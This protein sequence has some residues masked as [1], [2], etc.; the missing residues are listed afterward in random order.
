LA[1]ACQRIAASK[2]GSYNGNGRWD[3]CSRVA[4]LQH[5]CASSGIPGHPAKPCVPDSDSNI[6]ESQNPHRPK[7]FGLGPGQAYE[8]MQFYPPGWV[9]MP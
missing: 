8:E 9:P 3:G 6:Y 7:Y 4:G 2:S 1:D 5:F